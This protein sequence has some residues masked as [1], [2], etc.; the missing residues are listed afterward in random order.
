MW[1]GAG[2]SPAQQCPAPL[3]FPARGPGLGLSFSIAR[4]GGQGCAEPAGTAVGLEGACKT[5]APPPGKAGGSQWG[6]ALRFSHRLTQTGL[7]THSPH[8]PAHA[9]GCCRSPEAW[10][11]QPLALLP[12][13]L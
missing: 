13:Q 7:P 11:L 5:L 1:R 10:V 9:G 6:S 3:L 8:L 12:L 2:S 4:R